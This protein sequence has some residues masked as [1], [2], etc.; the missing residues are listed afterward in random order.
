MI[1][2]CFMICFYSFNEVFLIIFYCI[3][4]IIFFILSN[5]F[6]V[7]YFI[8]IVFIIKIDFVLVWRDRDI[9]DFVG[10]NRVMFWVRVIFVIVFLFGCIRLMVI[11]WFRFI[12][13]FF[14]GLIIFCCLRENIF[15]RCWKEIFV[16]LFNGLFICYCF[17]ILV[18]WICFIIKSIF[19]ISSFFVIRKGYYFVNIFF[20]VIF[21][22]FF[23]FMMFFVF[24]SVF[25]I[26][27]I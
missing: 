26:G 6:F 3:I 1:F 2:I 20:Y 21:G 23:K 8:G 7:V 13:S 9:W 17:I 25:I 27:V 16:V 22:F 14:W 4:D 18:K 19:G 12:E 10:N 15:G 24:N 5:F 11:I